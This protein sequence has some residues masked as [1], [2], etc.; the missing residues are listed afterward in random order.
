MR[1]D[2][3]LKN[4]TRIR[5]FIV[6]GVAALHLFFL[7]TLKMAKKNIEA[8]IENGINSRL[9]DIGH[10]VMDRAQNLYNNIRNTTTN[11]PIGILWKDW[12]F[13]ETHLS[14]NIGSGKKAN[15]F[16]GTQIG[17]PADFDDY[18]YSKSMWKKDEGKKRYANYLE[19]IKGQYDG[20][21]LF[22]ITSDN[23]PLYHLAQSY[24]N[25]MGE[26]GAIKGFD[27]A[28]AAAALGQTQK[29]GKLRYSYANYNYQSNPDGKDTIMGEIGGLALAKLDNESKKHS[30]VHYN[31]SR[32]YAINLYEKKEPSWTRYDTRGQVNG[33]N[34]STAASDTR[35]NNVNTIV[36][37]I[38]NHFNIPCYGCQYIYAENEF[39]GGQYSGITNT[40]LFNGGSM[41]GHY[42]AF[43]YGKDANVNDGVLY[44]TGEKYWDNDDP[45]NDDEKTGRNGR[46][47]LITYTND[48]FHTNRAGLTIIGRFHT[49]ASITG[50][51]TMDWKRDTTSTAVSQWGYSHGRNLL[52]RK[53]TIENGYHN[54]Y[55]RVWTFH[56]QYHR[57]MDCMRPFTEETGGGDG[58]DSKVNVLNS[59]PE[60]WKSIRSEEVGGMS[61]GG[62]RLWVH[63]VRNR[64][65]GMVNIAPTYEQFYE[66]NGSND[67]KNSIDVKKCMFSI[68]NLAWKD[69]FKKG[70]YSEYGLSKEQQ[71]PFGGRIMWFPPY[72]LSFDESVNVDWGGGSDFIGRGEKIYAYKNTTRS[73]TLKFTVLVDH[74]N[75]L[76]EWEHARELTPDGDDS[77]DNLG[78]KNVENTFGSYEQ[79]ILRFFAGCE[80][81]EVGSDVKAPVEQKINK[82]GK[83]IPF[84]KKTKD[85]IEFFMFF[86]NNYSG[87]DDRKDIDGV[88]KYLLNGVGYGNMNES[89]STTTIDGFSGDMFNMSNL[90]HVDGTDVG[91]YETSVSDK[92]GISCASVGRP[93]V[94][95]VGGST[96]E[97]SGK[98]RYDKTHSHNYEWMY[99][100]DNV[101]R[102]ELLRTKGEPDIQNYYD[103][104]SFGFNSSQG[105]EKAFGL[106]NITSDDEKKRIYSFSDIVQSIASESVGNVK[107]DLWDESKV[108]VLKK[109][110]KKKV[111]G[112]EC[113]GYASNH[114]YNDSNNRLAM[115]RAKTAG[116]VIQTYANMVDNELDIKYYVAD[117][118]GKTKNMDVNSKE[119]KAYRC[120]KVIVYF[121]DDKSTDPQSTA[122]AVETLVY[123]KDGVMVS[124]HNNNVS[125]TTVV[126]DRY[127][128]DD[129]KGVE[130][131]YRAVS[132]RSVSGYSNVDKEG[133]YEKNKK[134]MG[135]YDEERRFFETLPLESPF[136]LSKITEKVKYFNPAYHSITPEGFNSRLTF[137]H[138]CT[139]QGPTI[140]ASDTQ[141]GRMANNLAFGR[142][143]VCVLRIGD[144]F[145]TKVIIK[146]IAINYGQGGVMWDMNHEGIG[147]APMYADINMTIEFLGGSD[148][149]GPINRLQNA[150]S[151]N[152]YANTGIYDNRSDKV[153][154]DNNGNISRMFAFNPQYDT[155]KDG[156]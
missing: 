145:Y 65:N 57:L 11:M 85:Y 150:V 121:E 8:A 152:Y 72:N 67:K 144:F 80:M 149:S 148:I 101:T 126:V 99:R 41:F 28:K 140:G 113:Y 14:R 29:D 76:N 64:Y 18:L 86:P 94:D 53:P 117:P 17:S 137:L 7:N 130:K 43:Q 9:T 90:Y 102:H 26:V 124:H 81:L 55:C 59:D 118:N 82:D 10:K 45:S 24:P 48:L 109:K 58:G 122:T 88:I 151:F 25:D 127:G 77:V 15:D 143:P 2:E 56:H 5:I 68:E 97:L 30:K 147:V 138:Q 120:A 96:Y 6:E 131:G 44:S 63:G 100:V 12:K 31:S 19:Y 87:V 20:N 95:L 33:T 51:K 105:Y 116:K 128:Y 79:A 3:L 84:P 123:D 153:V 92:Y 52:K 32:P 69:T 50:E 93:V 47:D 119:A 129:S 74:P 142:A 91:G 23:T 139:R 21:A 110:F 108:L 146:S 104:K 60:S 37:N 136:G 114:G 73:G 141:N 4:K 154:F 27:Y 78:E 155:K 62:D 1:C 156:K 112:V 111:V 42:K 135:R 36:A 49:D 70:E 46:P 22:L 75:I 83:P 40:T 107:G 61:G 132:N 71:G 34:L 16:Y 38:D 134:K 35:Y 13:M 66:S 89:G 98:K 106:H 133:W 39:G 125:G 54:P 115:D 103:K